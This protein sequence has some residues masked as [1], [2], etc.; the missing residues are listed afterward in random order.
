MYSLTEVL[1][2]ANFLINWNQHDSLSLNNLHNCWHIIVL[3]TCM[4]DWTPVHFYSLYSKSCLIM[5]IGV[6][7]FLWSL[8]SHILKLKSL[9]GTLVHITFTIYLSLHFLLASISGSDFPLS[10]SE[11]YQK[12]RI[13]KILCELFWNILITLK[14]VKI[15]YTVST[16]WVQLDQTSLGLACQGIGAAILS[17]AFPELLSHVQFKISRYIYWLQII[18]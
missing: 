17:L 1:F 11:V 6:P 10:A 12:G 8:P 14:R 3:I 9:P 5:S 15:L 16:P 18:C 13:K 4:T 7:H 2:I